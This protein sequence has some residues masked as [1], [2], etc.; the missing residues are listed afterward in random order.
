MTITFKLENRI[1][2]YVSEPMTVTPDQYKDIIEMSKG[3]YVDGGYEMHL[4][5]GFMVVPP[6][7][8]RNSILTVQV[9]DNK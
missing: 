5:N 9:M 4:P 6:D 7:V 2:A 8:V 3:F 1:G